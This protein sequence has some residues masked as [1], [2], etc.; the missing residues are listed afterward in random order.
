MIAA[1]RRIAVELRDANYQPVDTLVL[2]TDLWGRAEG[3][4][5]LP[6]SG[7]TGNYQLRA[8]EAQG[9]RTSFS[10][11][12]TSVQVSDYK[13]PTFVVEKTAVG[14]PAS[15]TQPATVDGVATTY[16]GFPVAEAKVKASLSVMSGFWLRRSLPPPIPQACSNVRSR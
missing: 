5:T 12:Q 10:N 2:T 11:G 3:S 4:F 14:R 8:G 1:E 16:S 9:V 7:L 15:V 6:S 13:L